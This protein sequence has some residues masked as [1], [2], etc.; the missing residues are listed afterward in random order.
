MQ[1]ME[2]HSQ[3]DQHLK[4]DILLHLEIGTNSHEQ[5]ARLYCNGRPSLQRVCWTLHAAR[6]FSDCLV[7]QNGEEVF[8]H[9]CYQKQTF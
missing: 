5:E 8:T 4:Q 3:G 7:G 1:Y 9:H 2:H 6:D